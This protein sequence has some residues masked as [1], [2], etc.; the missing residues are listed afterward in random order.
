MSAPCVIM[1]REVKTM[2][3]KHKRRMLRD[4]APS[5][6]VSGDLSRIFSVNEILFMINFG[7][8]EGILQQSVG[9]PFS[10]MKQTSYATIQKVITY[11]A[12]DI[13]GKPNGDHD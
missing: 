8:S 12:N 13:N 9:Y 5:M 2:K 6:R 10:V 4:G 11:C 7:F 3:N 1:K